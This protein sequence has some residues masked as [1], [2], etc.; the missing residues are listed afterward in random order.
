MD[1]TFKERELRDLCAS[2]DLCEQKYGPEATRDLFALVSDIESSRSVAELE[3]IHDIVL[4][5]DSLFVRVGANLVARFVSGSV[6]G[7][8]QSDEPTNWSHV[9]RLR[10][11]SLEQ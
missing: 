10:L 3:T 11:V 7:G 1:I 2:T 9:R 5:R 4:E 6:G 8:A